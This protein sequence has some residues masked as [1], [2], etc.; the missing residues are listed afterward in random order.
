MG[1]DSFL[2]SGSSGS[3][4]IR[5]VPANNFAIII[6]KLKTARHSRPITRFQDFANFGDVIGLWK[7]GQAVADYFLDILSI[8]QP[9]NRCRNSSVRSMRA[10]HNPDSRFRTHVDSISS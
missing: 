5:G 4:N 3:A 6:P 1:S 9:S 7:T 2:N 8:A 10:L